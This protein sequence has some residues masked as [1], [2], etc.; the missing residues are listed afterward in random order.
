MCLVLLDQYVYPS[1]R[2]PPRVLQNGE[3]SSLNQLINGPIVVA[4]IKLQAPG[5]TTRVPR[6]RTGR[7][8]RGR[9][10][11]PR[12]PLRLR[13]VTPPASTQVI[14]DG[15]N[16]P[17]STSGSAGESESDLPRSAAEIGS[18]SEDDDPAH[19]YARVDAP[20]R[21]PDRERRPPSRHLS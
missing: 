21:Y 2:Y 19:R 3:Y 20:R 11:R 7:S 13:S 9:S 14:S 17:K 16:P 18:T 10:G 5:A 1:A 15:P 12:G 8:C 4:H 6:R